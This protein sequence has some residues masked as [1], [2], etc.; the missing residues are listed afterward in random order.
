MNLH[1]PH[2][3]L[4]GKIAKLHYSAIEIERGYMSNIGIG[5]VHKV[6]LM[7]WQQH[8][9][10]KYETSLMFVDEPPFRQKGVVF[11]C[12]QEIGK[13]AFGDWHWFSLEQ[14]IICN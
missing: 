5:N 2:K 12:L 11:Y 10:G 9:R 4:V 3:W 14:L 13:E 1:E 6:E 7:Y 8:S